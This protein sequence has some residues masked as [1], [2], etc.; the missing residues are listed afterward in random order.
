MASALIDASAMVAAF[1]SQEPEGPRYQD[2]L[3]LAALENWMLWT[4]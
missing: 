2:L 1:G 4:T 3:A